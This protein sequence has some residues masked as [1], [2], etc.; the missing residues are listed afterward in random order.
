MQGEKFRL[1]NKKNIRFSLDKK[2]G[3]LKIYIPLAI[4]LG[5]SIPDTA[6]KIQKKIEGLFEKEKFNIKNKKIN[7][8]VIEVFE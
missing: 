4:K 2:K 5:E 6:F 8:A 3:N 7:I 1:S